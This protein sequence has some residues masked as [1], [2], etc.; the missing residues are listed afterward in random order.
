MIPRRE[1]N[2]LRTVRILDGATQQAAMTQSPRS[3]LG[4]VRA[5]LGTSLEGAAGCR[6]FGW[7]LPRVSPALPLAWALV[8]C[9]S[10]PRRPFHA[11]NVWRWSYWERVFT[12]P[13]APVGQSWQQSSVQR[14]IWAMLGVQDISRKN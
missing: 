6:S 7:P 12:L 8:F 13:N 4:V 3:Y 14:P 1:K 2:R 10:F 9:T 5:G 11:A